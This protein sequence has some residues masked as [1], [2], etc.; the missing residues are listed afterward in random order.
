M[1][2]NVGFSASGICLTNYSYDNNQ[3]G[4]AT[5]SATPKNN[6]ATVVEKYQLIE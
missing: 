2:T 4:T 5:F 1:T 6:L 3:L